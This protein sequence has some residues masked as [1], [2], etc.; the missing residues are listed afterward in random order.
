MPLSKSEILAAND[1]RRRA[2]GLVRCVV[3]VPERERERLARY[4]TTYLSGE[5]SPKPSRAPSKRSGRS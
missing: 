3:W 5:Y 4:V 1:A 2:A